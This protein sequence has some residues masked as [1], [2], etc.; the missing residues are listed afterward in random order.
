MT[1]LHYAARKG[2]LQICQ[3]IIERVDDKNPKDLSG[4]TPL[5]HAAANGSMGVCRLI[6][7][8]VDERNPKTNQGK[9]PLDFADGHKNLHRLF[10]KRN[11]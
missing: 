4:M 11:L 7:K 10:N 2:Y 8:N 3:E 9:T 6:L 1:P 5:H